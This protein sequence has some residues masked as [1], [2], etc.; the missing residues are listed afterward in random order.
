[1]ATLKRLC[2][3]RN[4]SIYRQMLKQKEEGE[5]KEREFLLNQKKLDLQLNGV[6]WLIVLP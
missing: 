3:D 4:I 6:T 5:N 2:C 1:M